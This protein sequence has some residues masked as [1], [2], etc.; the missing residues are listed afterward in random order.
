MILAVVTLALVLPYC[1]AENKVDWE[2]ISRERP[3]LNKLKRTATDATS[4][5]QCKMGC[6]HC[7]E[8]SINGDDLSK[9]HERLNR[10]ENVDW[11]KMK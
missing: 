3:V 8:G 5:K 2:A 1:L 10:I 6:K 7:Q 9:S 11:N 4:A